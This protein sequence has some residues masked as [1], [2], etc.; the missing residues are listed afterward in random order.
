MRPAET[1]VVA[2]VSREMEE[3]LERLA[4]HAVVAW[5]GRDRPDVDVDKVKKAFCY[6]FGVRTS[7]ISVVRN[8]P[9]DFLVTFTHRHHRDAPVACRDFPYGSL[10]I[11]IREWQPMTHGDCGGTADLIQAKYTCYH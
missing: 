6:Q 7:D 10:D 9:E 5:L 2:T 8:F 11:R 4:T 3:E 1:F